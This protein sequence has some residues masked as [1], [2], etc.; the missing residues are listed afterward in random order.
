[1]RPF[2]SPP[3]VHLPAGP[4]FLKLIH[5]FVLLHDDQIPE[6]EPSVASI[7]KCRKA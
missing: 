6:E 2:H 7:I 5:H 3:E 4:G 1:M